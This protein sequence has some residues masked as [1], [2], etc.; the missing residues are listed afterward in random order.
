MSFAPEELFAV[1]IAAVAF[2]AG[3]LI[4]RA[5]TKRTRSVGLRLEAGPA[6]LRFTCA[7]CSGKFTHSRRT[8][9]AWE[10]GGR[11]FFCNAC[12]TKWQSTHAPS[13]HGRGARII[14]GEPSA[15]RGCLGMFAV[16]LA[17]PALL[18]LAVLQYV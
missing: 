10:K 2:L 14:T 16:L 8:I 4:W 17:I 18:A 3:F 7:G 12:H 11:S 13:G 15:K 5:R 1:A 9:S 6:N